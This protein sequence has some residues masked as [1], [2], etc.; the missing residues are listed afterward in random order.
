MMLFRAPHLQS[1]T[2][3]ASLALAA[4]SLTGA[5]LT[6]LFMALVGGPPEH[7]AGMVGLFMLVT[8][9]S[10]PLWLAGLFT[11]GAGGWAVLHHLGW[12]GPGSAVLYGALLNF[13]AFWA[14]AQDGGLAGPSL[15]AAAGAVVGL[16]VWAL[17]YRR[18]GPAAARHPAELGAGG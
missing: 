6:G 16:V 18:P 4:G 1:A 9:V 2:G 12:R 8:I 10:L 11:L 17:G 14:L 13:L 5:V 15:F 7:P 3:R